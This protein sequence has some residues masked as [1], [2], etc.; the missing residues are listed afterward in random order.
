MHLV[1]KAVKLHKH[2][3][4]PESQQKPHSTPMNSVPHS[5]TQHV[6]PA[7][8]HHQQQ[9]ASYQVPPPLPPKPHNSNSF[10]LPRGT[11]TWVY[12]CKGGEAAM[13]RSY[14]HSFN[15]NNNRNPINIVYV[16]GGDMEVPM[17]TLWHDSHVNSAPHAHMTHM[18][19]KRA[20]S[21]ICVVLPGQQRSPPNLLSSR[22]P[23]SRYETITRYLLLCVRVHV[24]YWFWVCIVLFPLT[25][26]IHPTHHTPHPQTYYT[27]SLI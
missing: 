13:W 10:P 6:A 2:L 14:L 1:K 26:H 7:A 15:D 21:V 23:T 4:Q 12:D 19:T 25:L 9:T 3:K 27:P 11:A 16:Y 8:L 18:R 20:Y 17:H 5:Q 22:E 24:F